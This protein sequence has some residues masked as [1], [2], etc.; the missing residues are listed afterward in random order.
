[1]PKY[2]IVYSS[3]TGNTRRMAE[4]FY[5]AAPKGSRLA[6]MREDV[7]PTEFD[8]VFVGFWV[9]KG[10]PNAQARDYLS[11]LQHTEVVLFA[12]L[13]ADPES[14]HAK[15]SLQ[16]AADLLAENCRVLDALAFRGAIDPKLIEAMR[17]RANPNSYHTPEQMRRSVEESAGHPNEAD[18]AKA[19]AYMEKFAPARG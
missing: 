1:M 5:E 9:D 2:L 10:M 14:D 12:T 8:A 11:S 16:K 3:R 4:A 19:R 13:G 7:D 17:K 15:T 6:E 18:F